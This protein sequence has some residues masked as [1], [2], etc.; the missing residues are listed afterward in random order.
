MLKESIKI[1]KTDLFLYITIV[2]ELWVI[3]YSEVDNSGE[4]E[5]KIKMPP[6]IMAKDKSLEKASEKINEII[7]TAQN[8]EPRQSRKTFAL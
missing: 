6:Y 5:M 4:N 3:C 7:K 1:G 8:H 2:D